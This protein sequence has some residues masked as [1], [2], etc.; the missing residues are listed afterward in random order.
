MAPLS[1]PG[2]DRSRVSPFCPI[3]ISVL[4]YHLY[5]L[6]CSESSKSL[7]L[8]F[9]LVQFRMSFVFGLVL[10]RYG[11]GLIVGFWFL[12]VNLIIVP[13][14]VLPRVSFAKYCHVTLS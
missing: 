14:P 8:K 2:V 1:S 7:S 9:P 4:L 6:F 11:N 13:L 12:T 3:M 10:F 5:S